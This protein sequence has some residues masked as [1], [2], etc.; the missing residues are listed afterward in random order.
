MPITKLDHVNLRTKD[1]DRLVGWYDDILG[2]K[3]GPRPGFAFGGAWM[4]CGA[5]AIVHIVADDDTTDYLPNQQLEHFA[6]SATDLDS[7]LGHLRFHKVAY[8]N[9]RLPQFETIQVNIHDCDGNHLHIDFPWNEQADIT[10]Y[11]GS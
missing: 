1:V 11:D 9:R 3:K 10:D 4:Y 5:S 6:L 8:E 2:L 7:F